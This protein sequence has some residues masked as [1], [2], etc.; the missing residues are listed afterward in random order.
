[1]TPEHPE[2]FKSFMDKSQNKKVS[3]SII[4]RFLEENDANVDHMLS[5]FE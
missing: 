4:L 5:S 2:I 1:L 3:N